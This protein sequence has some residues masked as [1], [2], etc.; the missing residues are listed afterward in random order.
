MDK[1]VLLVDD[2]DSLRLT[3]AANLELEGFDIVLSDIRMPGMSGVEMF[4]EIRNR[5]PELPVVLMTAFTAEENV[6]EAVETGVFTVLTKPFN[7]DAAVTILMRALR[8]PV[9]VVVDDVESVAT[10]AVAALEQMNLRAI[11]CTDPAEALQLVKDGKVD[12][13]VTDLVM[14]AMDGLT[15]IERALAFDEKIT[16]IVFSGAPEADTL[17]RQAASKGV[18]HCL[19]KPLDPRTL[20]STISKAR[21]TTAGRRN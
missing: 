8:L 6:S 15:L 5:H 10:T 20:A 3:I 13:C 9:I 11:A 16:I 2:E 7:M 14:P 21:A 1:R 19:R 12:V 17:M 18:F 4:E